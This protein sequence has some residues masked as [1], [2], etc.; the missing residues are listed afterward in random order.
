[1][2][3]RYLP[4]LAFDHSGH[5]SACDVSRNWCPRQKTSWHVFFQSARAILAAQPMTGDVIGCKALS[6]P[7]P[8]RSSRDPSLAIV[9]S[10]EAF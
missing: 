2:P 3:Q 1:M 7:Y 10:T 6:P 4:D 5:Q 8:K 9:P